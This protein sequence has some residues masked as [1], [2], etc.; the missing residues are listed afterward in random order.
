MREAKSEFRVCSGIMHSEWY[1]VAASRRKRETY[2]RARDHSDRFRGAAEPEGPT[3]EV[4]RV[5]A[6]HGDGEPVRDVETDGGDGDGAFKRHFGAKDRKSEE[7]GAGGA[8][9]DGA[10]RRF[11]AVV[12]NV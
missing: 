11:E 5:E 1:Q 12:H 9:D 8:E 2:P 10:D 3:F 6:G 4:S 7:E